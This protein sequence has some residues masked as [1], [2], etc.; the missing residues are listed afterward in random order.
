M[1]RDALVASFIL[2]IVVGSGWGQ[3]KVSTITDETTESSKAVMT[4]LRVR[5]A[6]HPEGFTLVG[7][8]DPGP[9]LLITA[10]CIP[11]KAKEDFT[12]F[13]TSHYAGMAAKTFMGGGVYVAATANDVADNFLASIAQDVVERWNSTSRRNNVES[14]EACLFLTQSS[15]KV[16]DQLE[17]ELKTKIINLSQYL[18]KGALTK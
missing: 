16:P 2:F 7:N 10:D 18:Q 17:S 14:L 12:C 11:R 3:I 15:C 8:N 4:A 1:N 5:L 13:Y 6:S 9:G